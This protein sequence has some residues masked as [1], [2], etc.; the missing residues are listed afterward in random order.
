METLQKQTLYACGCCKQTLPS[1]AFYVDKRTGLPGNYCKECRKSA[2]RKHRKAEKRT[3]V[4]RKTPVKNSNW[5]DQV[6][7]HEPPECQAGVLPTMLSH[8][9]TVHM[10]LCLSM[11]SHCK[12]YKCSIQMLASSSPFYITSTCSIIARNKKSKTLHVVMK[13]KTPGK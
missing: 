9:S 13:R 3:L 8:P 4:K 12:M 5:R 6:S 2:S 1:D 11:S 10:V 7:N